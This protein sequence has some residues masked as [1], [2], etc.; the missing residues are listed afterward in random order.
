MNADTLG[1][2]P[3]WQWLIFIAVPALSGFFGVLVGS[4]LSSR[5][6]AAQ[7]RHSFVERQLQELY[8]PLLG[9]RLEIEALAEVQAKVSSVGDSVWRQ[10]C[11]RFRADPVAMA[12]WCEE[13]KDT[14]TADIKY[15]NHQFEDV[16]LPGYKHM[17]VTFRDNL[18][19]AEPETRTH[20]AKLVAYVDLWLR[21][22]E[23]TI[24][25]DVM[26]EI[27]LRESELRPFYEDLQRTHDKLQ[28]RLRTGKV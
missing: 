5:R 8:S 11:D 22:L 24:P 23:D 27:D 20:F 4:L 18:W 1:A 6:E 16:L 15:N 10:H 26:H 21:W 28:N 25:A 19:L 17:V 7:R 12:K 13:H 14:Y 9:I 3:A 2:A